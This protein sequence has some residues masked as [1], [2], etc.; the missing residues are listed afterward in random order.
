M[1]N[2]KNKFNDLS[3]NS[4]SDINSDKKKIIFYI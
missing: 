3:M 4:N 2:N 1:K